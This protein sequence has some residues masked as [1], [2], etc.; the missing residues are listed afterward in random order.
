MQAETTREASNP[1]FLQLPDYLG[2]QKNALPNLPVGRAC[3]E[4]KSL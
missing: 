2:K 3:N 1:L 4:S